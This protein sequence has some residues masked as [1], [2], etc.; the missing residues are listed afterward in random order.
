[1]WREE[2]CSHLGKGRYPNLGEIDLG[3][4]WKKKKGSFQQPGSG[5]NRNE[6]LLGKGSFN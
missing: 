1:M 2:Y 3:A 5:T 6:H 4:H